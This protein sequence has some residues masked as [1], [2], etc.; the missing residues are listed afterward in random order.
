MILFLAEAHQPPV[1]H[2]AVNALIDLNSL[3]MCIL[4]FQLITSVPSSTQVPRS[5]LRVPWEV[6]IFSL[7]CH[8]F[9]LVSV[10]ALRD[11]P[12]TNGCL[13]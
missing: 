12:A 5:R 2:I 11:V 6:E 7:H 9:I 3:I 10:E 1:P 8:I 4:Q 13:L